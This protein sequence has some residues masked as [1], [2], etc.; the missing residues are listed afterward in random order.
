MPLVKAYDTATGDTY[1]VRET[2]PG[3]KTIGR[4]LSLNPPT[5]LQQAG[6]TSARK[7]TAAALK[8][9]DKL[10]AATTETPV[11]GEGKD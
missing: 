6:E 4:H 1:W 3:H 8:K 2:V 9:A 7:P 10:S 5:P 11:A